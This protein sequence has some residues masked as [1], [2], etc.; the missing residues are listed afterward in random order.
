MSLALL[1][2]YKVSLCRRFYLKPTQRWRLLYKRCV[3]FSF[4]GYMAKVLGIQG[5]ELSLVCIPFLMEEIWRKLNFLFYLF[6]DSSSCCRIWITTMWTVLGTYF[7]CLSTSSTNCG[8]LL[9]SL[10]LLICHLCPIFSGS[11]IVICALRYL[12]PSSGNAC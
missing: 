7:S 5:L 1:R 10:S 8:F 2:R 6:K 3:V 12:N 11:R 4:G 9:S